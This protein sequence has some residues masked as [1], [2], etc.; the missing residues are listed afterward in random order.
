MGR[1]LKALL[2]AAFC[3][4]KSEQTSSLDLMS[5][6]GS[7]RRSGR[8]RTS[9]AD[10]AKIVR[11]ESRPE[12]TL[13]R[14]KNQR[15]EE[16][17]SMLSS[18]L[19]SVPSDVED[20]DSRAIEDVE[21]DHGYNQPPKRRRISSVAC[22][23][24]NDVPSDFP[25][26]IVVLHLDLSRYASTANATAVKSLDTAIPIASGRKECPPHCSKSSRG[27]GTRRATPRKAIYKK[28]TRKSGRFVARTIAE[29]AIDNHSP[30][31]LPSPA[32]SAVTSPNL[33]LID[34]SGLEHQPSSVNTVQM[35]ILC[36][37]QLSPTEEI[38]SSLDEP[39]NVPLFALSDL[40][41]PPRS[42]Q[43]QG[44]KPISDS[45]PLGL[46]LNDAV[47]G[48]ISD[49]LYALV[50]ATEK[51]ETEG[52]PLVWAESRQ[53]LCEALPYYRQYQGGGQ[54]KGGVASGFMFDRQSLSRDYM[55]GTV[56]ISRAGGGLE[57]NEETGEMVVNGDQR[58]TSQVAA[59]LNNIKQ[60]NPVIIIAGARNST[61]HSKI[62]RTYSVLD[63]F[64]PTHVWSEKT[65]GKRIIRY[66]FEKLRP[67]ESSWWKGKGVIEPAKLGDLPRPFEHECQ[68]CLK[69]H[70][71]VYLNGWMCLNFYCSA[72]WKLTSGFEPNEDQL[73]Y[74][75]RF[76]KQHTSWPHSDGMYP[77]KPK[78]W[79]FSGTNSL[80]AKDLSWE[81]TRAIVCP[82]CGR[83]GSGVEWSMWEC[84]NI[85]C[86][87]KIKLQHKV[88]PPEAL[89]D[90][91][92]PL[93][94]AYMPSYDLHTDHA[95]LR[96]QFA[97]NY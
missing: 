55:D 45:I 53:E 14:P 51:P 69:V 67:S 82:D 54:H 43:G 44:S 49:I 78:S 5:D 56:I 8:K 59:V 22:K 29:A 61:S 63:H 16:A 9:N 25:S 6:M 77:L 12:R 47:L 76:L 92:Q 3:Q 21:D 83:C 86:K 87:K 32:I 31:S 48:P 84:K 38:T 79:A 23:S 40:P 39:A 2:E 41:T 33:N 80:F 46:A 11:E 95:T 20:D 75:P 88:V 10:C 58:V 17:A 60:F 90:W 74:D 94:H 62:H 91:F 24:R 34:N 70:Q 96:I 42:Q 19:S 89:R 52:H 4:V 66:R 65:G 73:R 68:T 7:L 15:S 37:V 50:Q 26:K 28:I 30:S 71:Q 97:H 27:K 18:P 1:E 85:H 36:D 35:P 64:K 81:A 93:S 57:R 13:V 72:F